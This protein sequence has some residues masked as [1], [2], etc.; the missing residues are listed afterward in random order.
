MA[1]FNPNF[2]QQVG[3]QT[4]NRGK[5]DSFSHLIAR[6]THVVQGPN[7]VG[8]NIPDIYYNDPTDLGTITFQLLNSPQSSTLSSDGNNVAKP[9]NSALKQYPIE[10]EFVNIIPG[11]GV[12]M[13]ESRGQRDFFYSA[14]YNLW[15]ATNHNALPDLGD[16]GDYINTVQR[17]Y[18]DSAN[19][20]Q[21]VNTSATGSLVF[22]LGPNFPEK[23]D[24]KTLRQFTGDVM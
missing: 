22:P 21:A 13:N 19:T 23:N 20:N 12:G 1:N 18:Q 7:L 14:P 15:N 16:Y 11:P 24:V 17:N 3:S 2:V 10:G 5:Q 4:Q 8:T 6:V 9:I